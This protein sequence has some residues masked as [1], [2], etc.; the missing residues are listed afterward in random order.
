MFVLNLTKK[1]EKFSTV[2]S[3]CLNEVIEKIGPCEKLYSSRVQIV[4]ILAVDNLPKSNKFFYFW[5][6]YFKLF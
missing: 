6:V 5:Y 3:I 4:K 1:F 2:S